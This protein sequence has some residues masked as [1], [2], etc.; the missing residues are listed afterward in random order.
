MELASAVGLSQNLGADD[1]RR[2]QV[3]RELD[4]LEAEAQGIAGGLAHQGLAESGDAFDQDVAAGEQCGQGFADDILVADDDLADLGF[5][6]SESAPEFGDAFGWRNLRS[7]SHA[8]SLFDV[9]QL[10][11]AVRAPP[12]GSD[13]G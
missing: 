8:F 10:M 1:V 11:P 9:F 3:G 2:H 12:N 5:G 13:R 7:R 4:A 6:A